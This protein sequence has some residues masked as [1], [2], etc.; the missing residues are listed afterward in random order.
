MLFSIP[1]VVDPSFEGPSQ[2]HVAL[3][4]RRLKKQAGGAACGNPWYR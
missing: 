4:V 2:T 3:F 1:I